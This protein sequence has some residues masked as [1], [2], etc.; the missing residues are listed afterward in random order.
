MVRP[1]Q[2]RFPLP[3]PAVVVCPFPALAVRVA[4]GTSARS[5][6]SHRRAPP[7]D[8]SSPEVMQRQGGRGEGK[9]EYRWEPRRVSELDRVSSRPL[10][11]ALPVGGRAG[12]RPDPGG[13][14]HRS[15][16]GEPGPGARV[17]CACVEGPGRGWRGDLLLGPGALSPL[18]AGAAR[19]ATPHG[20]LLSGAP[21][22]TPS[23]PTLPDPGG[24]LPQSCCQGPGG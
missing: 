10:Q 3:Q 22:C 5:P 21:G 18:G 15:R 2:A 19:P 4:S 9:L 6:A 7:A 8:S 16:P 23:S 24:R 11:G 13:L 20:P 1:G 14:R 17:A 12:R